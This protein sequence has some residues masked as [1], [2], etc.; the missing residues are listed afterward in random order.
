MSNNSIEF[1]GSSNAPAEHNYYVYIHT[2][3]SG[4]KYVGVT[5][6]PPE[7]RWNYGSGY[8]RNPYFTRAIKKYG[9]DNFE[10]EIVASGLTQY[11]ALYMEVDLIKKY[12][13]FHNG[14]NSSSGGEGLPD[15][16]LPRRAIEKS[17]RTNAKKVRQYTIDGKYIATYQSVADAGRNLGMR[18]SGAIGGCA[19]GEL[20]YAYGYLWV[21]DGNSPV[22]P[23]HIPEDY[24]F[25][26]EDGIGKPIP[27]LPMCKRENGQLGNK[28][29]SIKVTQ[30]DLEQ[31]KIKDWDSMAE[32]ARFIGCD[33]YEISKCV[34]GKRHTAGGFYWAK[35][36]EK[37]KSPIPE[38]YSVKRTVYQIDPSTKEIIG[39]FD[40]L[41][42]A[43]N[44]T[45]VPKQSISNVCNQLN[46]MMGGFYWMYK[47]KPYEIKER[48]QAKRKKVKCITSGKTF[49][50]MTIAANYF[51]FARSGIEACCQKRYKQTHG[52]EFEY[53]E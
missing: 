16:P 50:S 21:F 40:S 3:P 34:R 39:T 45:G 35:Q 5:R 10:H 38:S 28:R 36:R 46:I 9:W 24:L 14:Y 29:R 44:K 19:R 20:P 1:G 7:R 52:L 37:I 32:A 6:Q 41:Q 42:D 12:D 31:N 2:S 47:D 13:S 22:I 53:A 43:E 33:E 17:V 4:K 48:Y 11:D 25:G 23:D 30:Y 26:E 8:I 51:G 49:D 15:R 18:F 27:V